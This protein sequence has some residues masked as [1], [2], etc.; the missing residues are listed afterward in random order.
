[1]R[2]QTLH[3]ATLALALLV[4]CASSDANNGAVDA[5]MGGGPSDA[6]VADA[7]QPDA[8]GPA[9]AGPDARAGECIGKSD[10]TP[11]GDQTDRDCDH[12]DTCLNEAC[13]PHVDPLNT[14]CGDLS[15]TQ[16]TQPD[17]CDGLGA[18]LPNDTPLDTPCGD[19]TATTCNGRDVCDGAGACSAQLASLGTPC[20]NSTNS[21]CDGADSCDGAGTCVSNLAIDGTSCTDCPG[22]P[23]NTC[24]AGTCTCR[25][26]SLTTT[27][28]AGNGFDGNM[29]DVTALNTISVRKV[30]VLLAAGSYTIE[31]YFRAGTYVGHE[32]SA[33]G[34]TLVGSA[35]V[36]STGVTKL[37]PVPIALALQ[38]VGGQTYGFYITTTGGV[39]S[40]K[41]T[42]G[43][44]VGNV[45]ASD[46]N[47]QIK[48]GWGGK[49]PFSTANTPRVW[50]GKLVYD[51]CP[52]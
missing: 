14:P 33:T 3:S 51:L 10:G 32:S 25:A 47:L 52:P 13:Q 29:F 38:L 17:S 45:Y 43:T 27:T 26:T 15:A 1:M 41:Y 6:A 19:P 16:C 50:N 21:Q 46:A 34:W 9:D 4:A 44:A 24:E 5:S 30:S 48:E 7:A 11:C 8:A 2:R 23:C 20:G 22:P 39:G 28:A 12:P 35:A 49:Y 37:T 31:I 18:C 40:M 36:T 42:N